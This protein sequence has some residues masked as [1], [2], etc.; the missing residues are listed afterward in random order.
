MKNKIVI[1][2]LIFTLV[3]IGTYY[4]TNTLVITNHRIKLGNQ[5]KKIKIAHVSDIHSSKIDQL[6]KQ[7][8]SALKEINP[9]VIFITGDLAT[10]QANQEGYL[11]II[12]NF[13]A[14]LGVFFVLGNWEYWEPVNN[15]VNLLKNNHIHFLKNKIF[16]L[17][18]EI[19]IIGFDDSEEGSPELNLHKRIDN[20]K[21]N[22]G[23]F[24]SPIYFE[25]TASFLDLNFSGHTHGGQIRLPF[26]GGLWLP[27]GSGNYDQGWFSKNN[28]KMYVSRGIGTSIIP[29]RFNCSPELAII[30]LE[31]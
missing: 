16:K 4:H 8:F 15:L 1:T 9:D 7:L 26:L 25:K 11:E 19:T 23:L 5:N 24:H 14:P 6:E 12:K 28:S 21:I 31:Y 3:F 29:I 10:P 18:N 13:S 20:E 30:E 17:N 22:I 27:Q 2:I